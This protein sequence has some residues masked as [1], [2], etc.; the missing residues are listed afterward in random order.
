[1]INLI[2]NSL[3]SGFIYKLIYLHLHPQIGLFTIIRHT[4]IQQKVKIGARSYL[5]NVYLGSYCE[6]LNSVNLINT[7]IGKYNKVYDSAKLTNVTLGDYSYISYNCHIANAMIGK[8]CSIGS[9]SRIGLGIHPSRKYVST[10]PSFYS[11][12]KQIP[13]SFVKKNKFKEFEEIFIGNDVWIGTRV[14]ILDGICIEDGAIIAAGTVVTKN[15][16]AY[17]VVSG[18][19]AVVKRYRFNNKQIKLLLNLKWWDKGLEWIKSNADKFTNINLIIP[20]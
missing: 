1:M 18:V 6:V 7:S 3:L 11:S 8:F 9:D 10:H 12:G 2:I 15:V 16:P 13:L 5:E 20:Q 17:A 4:K 14:T 19:P